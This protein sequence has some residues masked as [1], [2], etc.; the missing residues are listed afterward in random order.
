[1]DRNGYSKQTYF[2]LHLPMKISIETDLPA[3]LITNL[4]LQYYSRKV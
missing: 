2:T 3:V 4:L 1:M